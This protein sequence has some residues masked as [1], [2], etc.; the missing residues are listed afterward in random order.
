MVIPPQETGHIAL[1]KPVL[2]F[3]SAIPALISRPFWAWLPS[4]DG[5]KFGLHF[6]MFFLL[7]GI[8][9]VF[10]NLIYGVGIIS[11]ASG[12]GTICYMPYLAD[13][14]GRK[15]LSEIFGVVSIPYMC[16]S[17]LFPIAVGFIFQNYGKNVMLYCLIGVALLSIICFIESNIEYKEL[18]N[19]RL[20]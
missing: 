10:Y 7:I 1:I 16:L 20:S 18:R 19:G 11:F 2:I 14:W 13:R 6:G 17:G 9:S 4:R 12:A 15:R 8:I 3:S 5:A